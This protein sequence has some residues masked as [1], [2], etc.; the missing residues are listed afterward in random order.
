MGLLLHK[1]LSVKNETG[2]PL[3]P[4]SVC[5]SPCSETRSVDAWWKHCRHAHPSVPP[6]LHRTVTEKPKEP[7]TVSVHVIHQYVTESYQ[8]PG[9][10]CMGVL[11]KLRML[12]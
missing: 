1:C 8:R 2:L 3:S 6:T 4:P 5:P 11:S 9:C 7:E 10:R 12:N